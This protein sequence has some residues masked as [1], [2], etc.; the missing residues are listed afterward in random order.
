[1]VWRCEKCFGKLMFCVGGLI[2]LGSG[3]CL[4]RDSHIERSERTT[5]SGSWIG[6]RTF[7]LELKLPFEFLVEGWLFEKWSDDWIFELKDR[8]MILVIVGTRRVAHSLSKDSKEYWFGDWPKIALFL[9]RGLKDFCFSGRLKRVEKIRQLHRKVV[10]LLSSKGVVL[11]RSLWCLESV[12]WETDVSE[13][14]CKGVG[15]G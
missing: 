1:M 13:E 2:D 4:R 12:Q 3:D 14:G 11:C 9:L 10:S 6:R 15:N 8:L 5:R 7:R